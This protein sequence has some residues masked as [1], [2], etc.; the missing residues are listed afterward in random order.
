[1]WEVMSIERESNM[2]RGIIDRFEEE[3]AV[4][5]IITKEPYF[6]DIKKNKLPKDAVQGDVLIVGEKI[7]IDEKETQKRKAHIDELFEELFEE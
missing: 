3:Y 2:L 5:E 1:M 6:I 7:T 4:V